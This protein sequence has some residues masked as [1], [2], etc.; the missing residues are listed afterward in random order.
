IDKGNRIV[1][2]NITYKSETPYVNEERP[3]YRRRAHHGG[4][5]VLP[6]QGTLLGDSGRERERRS[7]VRPEVA[8]QT[9]ES[10]IGGDDTRK[11]R[12]VRTCARAQTDHA[13]RYIPCKCRATA[14]CDSLLSCGKEV[15]GQ[16][17][18]QRMHVGGSFPSSGQLREI[19]RENNRGRSGSSDPRKG[20]LTFFGSS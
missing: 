2:L 10:G 9:L 6:W 5:R 8:L 20:A 3:I 11:G 16:L 14:V 4:P 12:S 17:Q 19:T 15:S 7:H 18:P 13:V 1:L